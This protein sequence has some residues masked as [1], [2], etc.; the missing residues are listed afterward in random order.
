MDGFFVVYIGAGVIIMGLFV[1]SLMV[2][3]DRKNEKP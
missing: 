2:G 1:A 3:K